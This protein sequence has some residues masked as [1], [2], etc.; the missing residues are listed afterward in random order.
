M[1]SLDIENQKY[2]TLVWHF[3]FKGTRHQMMGFETVINM[4]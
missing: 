3:K 1:A 2:L 4:L